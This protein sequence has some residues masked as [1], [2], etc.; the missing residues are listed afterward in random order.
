MDVLGI[1]DECG[2]GAFVHDLRHGAARIEV[3]FG[4]TIEF[5]GFGCRKGEFLGLGAEDLAGDGAFP[6]KHFHEMAR[7][8]GAVGE[9]GGANHFGIGEVGAACGAEFSEGCR[10]ETG[11]RGENQFHFALKG[12]PSS[13]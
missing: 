1:L 12:S 2:A 7:G 11:K 3:D 9:S 8:G 6:G 4:E 5:R 10:G 13:V